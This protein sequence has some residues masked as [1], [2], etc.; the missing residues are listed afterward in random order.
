MIKRKLSTVDIFTVLINLVPLWGVW[1]NGWD[2]KQIFLIY[3]VE[4][5]IVGL[6]NVLKMLIVTQIK[7]ED[8]WNEDTNTKMPG[9]FF[10]FFFINHYGFFVTIQMM[11]FFGTSKLIDTMNP[12]KVFTILPSLMDGY[13][14]ALLWGFVGVYALRMVVDF[15]F[16]GEFRTISLG[17]LMF[18]P[19]MRIF[20]Q[21]FVVII[22][23]FVLSF[24]AGKVFMVVFIIVKIFFEVIMNYDRVLALA[25]K[26]NRIKEEIKKSGH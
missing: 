1:F 5:I 14:R 4:S 21:Q 8:V 23:G 13:T 22:G 25:E 9:Y 6:F 17:R 19:Y 7:K 3:C 16:S 11:F 18:S 10:I 15:I 2:P 26:K 24:G 12:I 20:V